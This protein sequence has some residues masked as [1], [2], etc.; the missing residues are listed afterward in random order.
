MSHCFTLRLTCG[1]FILPFLQ[2]RSSFHLSHWFRRFRT[3][4]RHS[5]SPCG[6]FSA[7]LRP[8]S[9]F[10][11]SV[12]AQT[13]ESFCLCVFVFLEGKNPWTLQDDLSNQR[14]RGRR[15][16]CFHQPRYEVLI[17]C[18]R[19]LHHNH[20]HSLYTHSLL[21]H[22]QYTVLFTAVHL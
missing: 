18:C 3:S 16:Q 6:R 10:L 4:S 14:R 19:T 12:R 13:P 17:S 1:A 5:C 11:L 22:I 20:T 15:F 21:L 8:N 9:T 2:E 7:T